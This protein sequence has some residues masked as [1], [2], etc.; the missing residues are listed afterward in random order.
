MALLLDT[1]TTPPGGWRYVQPETKCEMT[2]ESLEALVAQVVRHRD[3][4]HI[5]PVGRE[6]VGRD[7]QR[8]IC[9]RIDPRFGREEPAE[10]AR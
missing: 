3:Y 7:I 10:I 1:R 2:S 5:E 9:A 4:K 6:D 8:Q